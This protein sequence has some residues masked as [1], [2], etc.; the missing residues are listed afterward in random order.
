MTERPQLRRLHGDHVYEHPG[1]ARSSLE[2]H[3]RKSTDEI[4]QSLRPGAKSP[5]S[6]KSDG[7]I[8][9]G[10]TRVKVLEERGYPIEELWDGRSLDDGP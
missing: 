10:N 8:M 1:S 5:L 7:T 2:Y 6:V 9:Q 4:V 3:R